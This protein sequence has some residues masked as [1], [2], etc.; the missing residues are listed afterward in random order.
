LMCR[1]ADD[2]VILYLPPYPQDF[3]TA[4]LWVRT[5]AAEKTEVDQVDFWNDPSLHEGDEIR[6]PYLDLGATTN[7][8][9]LLDSWIHFKRQPPRKVVAALQTTDFS[10]H[11]KGA[12]VRSET[13]LFAA[14][15]GPEPPKPRPRKFIY[16]RPFFVFLWRE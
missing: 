4:C 8:R 5:W 9:D 13:T 14:P 16:D 3:S 12:S 1:E 11:E 10:L 6:I 2:T 7:F 15:F